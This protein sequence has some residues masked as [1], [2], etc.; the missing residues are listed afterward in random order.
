MA[1]Q[2]PEHNL[3][4]QK[5]VFNSTTFVSRDIVYTVY[6]T[7]VKGR[8]TCGPP[9]MAR[10]AVHFGKTKYSRLARTRI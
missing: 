10:H 6:T 1:S 3:K 9:Q 8:V 2:C 5:N 4:Q 7:R